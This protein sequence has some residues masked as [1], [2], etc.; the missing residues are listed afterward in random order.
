MTDEQDARNAEINERIKACDHWPYKVPD[1][2]IYCTKCGC[3]FAA[4]YMTRRLAVLPIQLDED[5]DDP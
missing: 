1:G 3:Q 5:D 2:A 4:L